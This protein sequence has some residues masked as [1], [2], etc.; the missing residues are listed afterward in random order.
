VSE[1]VAPDYSQQEWRDNNPGYPLSA[2]RMRHI[3]AGVAADEAFTLAVE[4]WLNDNKAALG[5]GGKILESELP[6]SVVPA[7]EHNLGEVEGTVKLDCSKY[8][9]FTLTA[10]GNVTLEVINSREAPVE[11]TV[12]GN[13]NGHSLSF[14]NGEWE[15][16]KPTFGTGAF[17]VSGLAFPEASKV[18]WWGTELPSTVE[19]SRSTVVT[20][21]YEPTGA[22]EAVF[23]NATAGAFAIPLPAPAPG[24]T[25]WRFTV[26]NT[27]TNTNVVTVEPK[28]GE[29]FGAEGDGTPTKKLKLGKGQVYYAITVISDGSNYHVI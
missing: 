1:P 15:G 12:T 4:E 7:V 25:G 16:E 8:T 13:L 23:A 18:I 22:G 17:T 9:L 5:S 26:V 11:F 6:E 3:E 28:A 27:S 14:A 20:G 29:I 21:A 24:N 19:S 10:K 2:L